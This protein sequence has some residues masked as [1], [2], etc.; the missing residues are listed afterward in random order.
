MLTKKTNTF[1]ETFFE[2]LSGNIFKTSSS[3]AVFERFFK[4]AFD[5]PYQL[6][7]IAGTDS[8]LLPQY[9]YEKYAEDSSIK[10]RKFVFFEQPDVIEALPDIEYPDWIQIQP[11]DADFRDLSSDWIEYMM[12]KRM[13]LYKSIAVVDELNNSVKKLWRKVKDKY[14]NLRFT[15]LANNYSRPFVQAQLKNYPHNITPIKTHKNALKGKKAILIAGGPSLD[16]AIDWIKEVQD[17]FF[18]FTVGRVAKKLLDEGLVPD[19]IA[20]V[21]PHELS[22]DNSKHM[23]HFSDHAILL[24][25]YHIA[26]RLLN[27]WPGAAMYFGELYP[28]QSASGNSTSPGPTVMHSAL[29]QAAFLGCDEIYLAGADLCFHKG[30]THASGSAEAEVGSIGI[31]DMATVETYS[32]EQADSDI[33]FAHGVQALD[34]IAEYLDRTRDIKVYNL[35][36]NA[37]KVESVELREPTQVVLPA[38]SDKLNLFERMHQSLVFSKKIHDEELSER[39]QTMQKERKFASKAEKLAKDGFKHI[40]TKKK[41]EQESSFE[42]AQ[43]LR[44]KLDKHLGDKAHMIFHYGY[45]Y[46]SEVLKPVEDQSNL[47]QEEKVHALFHYLKAMKKTL[48]DYVEL[49]EAVIDE[50]KFTQREFALDSL[51]CGLLPR[52][53]E[54]R[55][56]GR[57]QRW[58][59]HHAWPEHDTEQTACL[60][61]A[62][63]TFEDDIRSKETRQSSLLRAQAFGVDNLIDKIKSVFDSKNL[64]ELDSLK[65][66]VESLKNPIDSEGL[67]LLMEAAEQSVESPGSE[68]ETLENIDHPKLKVFVKSY[69]LSKYMATAQHDKALKMLQDLCAFSDDY[70]IPYA[71]YLNLLGR[72]DLAT[73][74]ALELFKK[75]TEN[76]PA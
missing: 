28:W 46:F 10:G 11:D 75:D 57:Y 38:P 5:P 14:A 32:G 40:S 18:I 61:E 4:D 50:I 16:Q 17:R 36:P 43:K 53:Q 25:C 63:T 69:L 56:T 26:P 13:G 7:L 52:W 15:D 3:K 31:K 30:Q 65:R 64:D 1:G 68:I 60:D 21:D 72:P 58:V 76:F 54:K 24:N 8:G 6:F 59:L 51:P 12:T 66:P 27:Q 70:I 20:S 2:E 9:I 74:L 67:S 71:D 22:Y 42:K 55:E 35:S 23:F 19:F 47:T 48:N 29:V 37:A 39:L 62:K 44:I 41:Q 49:I 34:S 73:D 33:P 45:A